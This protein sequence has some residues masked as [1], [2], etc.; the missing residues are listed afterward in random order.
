MQHLLHN[1]K[2]Q[3]EGL[4]NQQKWK[5]LVDDEPNICMVYKMVLEDA[6]HDAFHTQIPS[7]HLGIQP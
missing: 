1:Q 3:G 5:S 7:K 2:T 6:G 4:H